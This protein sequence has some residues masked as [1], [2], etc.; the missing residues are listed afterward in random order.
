[1]LKMPRAITGSFLVVIFL[2]AAVGCTSKNTKE[3]ANTLHLVSIAKIK[4]L[5]PAQTND[6]YSA[7]E[8]A[9]VYEGLLQY[10][11][12]K[13]PYVLI[14]A[15]AESMPEI[16]KDGR[17][18]IFHI[19]KGVLF[20]DDPSFKTT[21]GKGR[22]VTAEDF[23]YSFKRIADLKNTSPNWWLFEDKIVGLNDWRDST[24]LEP[25]YSKPVEGLKALDR[26]TFQV[27]LIKRSAQF[28]FV[29][30]MPQ[31][32][33]VPHEAVSHYG[34][35][36]I[37]HPVGT[38]AYRLGDHS[39]SNRFIWEKNPT[40]RMELFPSEGEASDKKEG[41]LADAGKPLPL[42]DRIVLQIYEEDQPR[43]LNFMAGNVDLISIPKDNF[44]QAIDENKELSSELKA[45]GMQLSKSPELDVTHFGF[46]MVDPLLGKNKLLRQ[47][48]SL[49]Y[50][51]GPEIDL[52]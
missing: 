44:T 48:L 39:Q 21:L 3:P 38:G 30:A 42:T 40:Y 6:L 19:K 25:D 27:K 36:F 10:H 35:E 41:Y 32:S 50:D 17:T 22:E 47:A 28:L 15:L 52:F 8:T 49:A 26:Y 16:S 12:L 31:T 13:R 2:T 18:L 14:P 7:R 34:K 9:R 20:Q 46:N 43:W 24:K 23:V 29:L 11:Y 45:K 5:D 1:M 51:T 37:N 4:G 33:V